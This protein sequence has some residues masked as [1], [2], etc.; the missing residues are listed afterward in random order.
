MKIKNK[1]RLVLLFWTL[2]AS[3]DM[4]NH[5]LLL[6][7]N[8]DKEYEYRLL[9]D[10]TDLKEGLYIYTINEQDSARPLFVRG[11][12]G[13]WAYTINNQSPDSTLNIYLF[14]KKEITS[15]IIKQHDYKR[16]RYKVKDLERLKW[17]VTI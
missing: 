12:D 5:R 13:A 7:N 4:D 10:T 14:D 17:R 2:L 8:T 15:N 3:C 6:I 16:L 11:G 1:N 9:S